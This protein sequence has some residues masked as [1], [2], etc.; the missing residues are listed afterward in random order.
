MFRCSCGFESEHPLHLGG[1]M[2]NFM[3]ECDLP[4]YCDNCNIVITRNVKTKT[5]IKKFNRCPNCKRKVQHYGEITDQ[6]K[7]NWE[8]IFDWRIDDDQH[9][10]LQDELYH[11]PKCKQNK[12]KFEDFGYW[13]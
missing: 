2:M 3:K 10:V 11:C 12:L 13:D 6:L 1:G 8:D 9:Y 7:Y 4:F 5:E